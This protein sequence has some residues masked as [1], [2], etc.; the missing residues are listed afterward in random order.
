LCV[1]GGLALLVPAER[2]ARAWRGREAGGGGAVQ[3]GS[4]RSCRGAGGVGAT[5]CPLAP[6]AAIAT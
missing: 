4:A 1:H 2:G 6:A 3:P 5:P